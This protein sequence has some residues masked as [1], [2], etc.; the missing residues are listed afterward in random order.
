MNSIKRL[1][2][3]GKLK[4]S[5]A[6]GALLSFAVFPEGRTSETTERSSEITNEKFAS[7]EFNPDEVT[8]EWDDAYL[9]SSREDASEELERLK[10]I[11]QEINETFSPKFEKLRGPIYLISGK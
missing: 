5:L 6:L 8:T 11:P 1:I 7:E 4:G 9:F 10:K 3:S 2:F